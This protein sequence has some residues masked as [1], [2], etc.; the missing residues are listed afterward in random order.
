MNTGMGELPEGLTDDEILIYTQRVRQGFVNDVTRNGFPVKPR[1][2]EVFL[3]ALADMDR[4][5]MGNKRIGANEKQSHAD[6]LVAAALVSLGNQFNNGN[7]F[8][9][10][11]ASAV[12]VEVDKIPLVETLPGET[13][14][15]LSD[16]THKSFIAKIEN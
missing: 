4:V 8:K 11:G 7:P 12:E 10:P 1:E 13:D 3:S 6:S 16:E 2:Q 14:I 9:G 5:A 15:G